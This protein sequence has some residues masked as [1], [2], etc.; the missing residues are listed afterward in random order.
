MAATTRTTS[1][2]DINREQPVVI[3]HD[4]RSPQVATLPLRRMLRGGPFTKK[5]ATERN[6]S[7]GQLPIHG[8]AGEKS[9]S[10][11][12]DQRQH[13]AGSAIILTG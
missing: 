8:P 11:S 6:V 13:G 1:R 9:H 2:A 3:R 12:P 5:R 4:L 10:P 7:P